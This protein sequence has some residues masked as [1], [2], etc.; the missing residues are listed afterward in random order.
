MAPFEIVE[1]D[2]ESTQ[3]I[4]VVGVGGAGNNAVNHMITSGV[5][6]VEFIAINTDK[7]VL[8]KTPANTIIQIGEKVTK[9]QGAG[10]K[11]DNGRKAAEE[12]AEEITQA[13]KGADMVFITA[14]MGGGTGTG[15]A[16]V[17]ARIAQEMEILTV[18]VVT[19]PFLFE[20]KTRI[21]QAELGI[22][23][24]YGH[25]D[26]L[27]VIPNERLKVIETP[28]KLTFHNAFKMADDVLKTAVQSIAELIN[29]TGY[30]NLDFADVS[31]VM[32]GAGIAHMGVG[33]GNG[34]E[35][36][37]IAAKMAISSPL[38]ETSIMGA[39]GIIASI[40][41][42]VDVGLDEVSGSMEMIAKEIHED[43]NLIFGV[44]FDPELTDTM[45]ITVIATSFDEDVLAKESQAASDTG[46]GAF[47]STL[48]TTPLSVPG[49]QQPSQPPAAADNQE[50]ENSEK[51][52]AK[53]DDFQDFDNIMDLLT[54]KNK[55]KN[56]YD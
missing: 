25:V 1:S 16:P 5:R 34:K 48:N 3:V 26:A 9:G 49:R 47:V 53:S 43:A 7:Q 37:E 23:E 33:H 18:G 20:S 39:R 51:T 17:V 2:G 14:G 11:P 19:K 28:E 22:T 6:G 54:S 41:I 50:S 10:G 56:L 4:K 46:V 27:I 15:A 30:M 31:S 38:L 13:L 24:L 40:T 32:K 44:A 8:I 35:K 29:V 45:K 42:P 21:A 12:S 52:T 55:N 36:A